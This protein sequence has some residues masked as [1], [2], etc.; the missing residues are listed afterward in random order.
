M[1]DLPEAR[2]WDHLDR[3]GVPFRQSK[4]ALI[5]AYGSVPV[6]W[7]TD[8]DD[9]IL[10][11][12]PLLPGASPLSFNCWVSQDP[13]PVPHYLSACFRKPPTLIKRIFSGRR[14]ELAFGEVKRALTR[15]LGE[16]TASSVSNTVA[17]HWDFG[18]ARVAATCFPPRLQRDFGPNR[19]LALDQEAAHEVSIAVEPAWTPDPDADQKQWLATFVPLQALAPSAVPRRYLPWFRWQRATDNRP[20]TGYGCSVDGCGFVIVDGDF[21]ITVPINQISAVRRDVLTPAKGGGGVMLGID[22][23]LPDQ[24]SRQPYAVDVQQVG[25]HPDALKSEAEVLSRVLGVPLRE[26]QQADC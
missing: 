10:P 7:T 5:A 16:P 1:T 24:G 20:A 11:G 23:A 2:L 4:G 6:G 22:Y 21:A 3:L 18:L 25:Y 26:S 8:L 17:C 9:C 15:D 13:R 14:A 19:R 12:K